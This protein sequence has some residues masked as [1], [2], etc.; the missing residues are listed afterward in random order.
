MST[1][2]LAFHVHLFTFLAVV[3]TTLQ[4]IARYYC[5]CHL[6]C[7]QRPFLLAP[8]TQLNHQLPKMRC[9]TRLAA[10]QLVLAVVAVTTLVEAA[11]RY[12]AP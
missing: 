4:S 12:T 9:L 10:L 6:C 7:V 2:P 11:S 3:P 5:N 8:V 1:H